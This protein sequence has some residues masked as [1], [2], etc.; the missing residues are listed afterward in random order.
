VGHG[1]V[2]ARVCLFFHV[3]EDKV[4]SKPS[5][6]SYKA[7]LLFVHLLS[8]RLFGRALLKVSRQENTLP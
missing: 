7:I 3:N 1:E 6:N 2:E 8:H 4:P 5:P